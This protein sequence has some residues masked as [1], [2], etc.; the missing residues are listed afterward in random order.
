MAKL[1]QI[2]DCHID[3][4]P[5]VMGVN[6]HINLKKIIQKI[7]LIDF[8]ALL[9]SGDLTHNG[10]INAYQILKKILS[11]IKKPIFIIA[12]NHDNIQH[13]EQQFN[14]NLFKSFTLGNWEVVSV[15]SV[16]AEKTSGLTTQT[17]LKELDI[18]LSKSCSN[19]IMVVL[20]HPI[21][22]INSNWDDQL[23]LENPQDLLQILT[24]HSKIRSVVFGHAHEAAEFSHANFKIILCPS[25]ALQFNQEPKIGFNEFTLGDTHFNYKTQWI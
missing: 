24:K 13:L 10:T 8:D 25:T 9:I 18:L 6:S 20:H 3:D 4:Q 12:G 15:N 22:P 11:P 5:I 23:S 17:A 19:N 7:N 14:K 1:I 21:V 16:Q 2:S